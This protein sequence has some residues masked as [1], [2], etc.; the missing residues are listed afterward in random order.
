MIRNAEM[1]HGLG[2][3]FQ[4]VSAAGGLNP[5]VAQA[6]PEREPAD[7]LD[8]YWAEAKRYYLHGDFPRYATPAWRELPP[9]DPR[10]FAGLMH[11]AENWRKYGDDIADDLNDAIKPRGPIH[12]RP[13]LA[14]LDQRHDDTIARNRRGRGNEA[15][16]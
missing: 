9:D 7:I 15:A 16:A 12:L 13:T 10:K 1:P 4:E 5:T 6:Q 11:Y 3:A 2:A 14:E 8:A